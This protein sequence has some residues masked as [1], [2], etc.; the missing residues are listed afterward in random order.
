MNE[1][2]VLG[3]LVAS[4]GSIVALVKFWMDMGEARLKAESADRAN[5]MLAAKLDLLASGLSEYKVDAAK[6]FASYTAVQVAETRFASAV[7]GMRADFG[8]LTE[9]LDRL[10]ERMD[11]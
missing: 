5:T 4:G 3:A 8:R 6:Q 9:R 7:E 11:K 2:L 10:I 1:Y